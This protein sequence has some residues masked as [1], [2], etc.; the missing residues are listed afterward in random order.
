MDSCSIYLF[1]ELGNIGHVSAI[2]A[3]ISAIIGA[4]IVV[5]SDNI[6]EKQ[7]RK[8]EQKNE[9][10]RAYSQLKGFEYSILQT[11]KLYSV[12]YI[13]HLYLSHISIIHLPDTADEKLSYIEQHPVLV[14]RVDEAR[15]RQ[16]E[17]ALE[18][19]KSRETLEKYLT[20]IELSFSDSPKIKSLK[21]SIDK[22]MK[23]LYDYWDQIKKDYEAA[24]KQESHIKK[25]RNKM[26]FLKED[27]LNRY[28][29]KTEKL[30][31]GIDN[32][33][34]YL[35]AELDDTES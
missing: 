2:I 10:K 1:N 31:N 3:L 30:K 34:S 22:S 9:R 26:W 20:D 27:Y 8:Q 18:M 13:D 4:S 6:I 14:R 12:S 25:K 7:R 17:S 5:A 11:C 16:N 33:L 28:P 24:T 15:Y 23:N 21:N 19:G 29:K 35:E 32:L